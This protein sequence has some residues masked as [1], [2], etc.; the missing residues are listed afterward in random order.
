MEG[1]TKYLPTQ[2]DHD[3]EGKHEKIELKEDFFGDIRKLESEPEFAVENYFFIQKFK[4]SQFCKQIGYD[5]NRIPKHSIRSFDGFQ[6][7]VCCYRTKTEQNLDHHSAIHVKEDYEAN[8]KKLDEEFK[9]KKITEVKY[10]AEKEKLNAVIEKCKVQNCT[11]STFRTKKNKS[12]YPNF[13]KHNE[14][15][16][17][18]K[19]FWCP[20]DQ[21]KRSLKYGDD[22]FKRKSEINRHLKVSN[23]CKNCKFSLLFYFIYINILRFS[24]LMINY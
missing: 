1:F 12:N 20:N 5:V 4:F 13:Q 16:H 24:S 19:E 21:C 10:L 14:K 3:K 17:S 18:D 6:C 23:S 8:V 2:K 7:F 9:E 22:P 11:Y 15:W